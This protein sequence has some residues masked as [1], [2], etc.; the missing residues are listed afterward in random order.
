[1]IPGQ[2]PRCVALS[3]ADGWRLLFA[4]HTRVLASTAAF[5]SALLDFDLQ[6]TVVF[7]GKEWGFTGGILGTGA[8]G[9]VYDAE[10]VTTGERA[11]VK[12]LNTSAMTPWLRNQT[13]AEVNAKAM[14]TYAPQGGVGSRIPSSLLPAGA[15]VGVARPPAHREVHRPASGAPRT[16]TPQRQSPR[17]MC[18]RPPS[19]AW[20]ACRWARG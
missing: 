16:P 18:Q 7:H 20:C 3:R 13:V 9:Q 10:C 2:P 19:G 8:Y 14:G 4:A 17:A 6:Q 5:M 15:R 11:A 12:V 1:M